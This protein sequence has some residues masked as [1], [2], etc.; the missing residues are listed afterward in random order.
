MY[1]RLIYAIM[2]YMKAVSC[3]ESFIECTVNVHAHALILNN[4]YLTLL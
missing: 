2:L 3:M 1:K 4:Q